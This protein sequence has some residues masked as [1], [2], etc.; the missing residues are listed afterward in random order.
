MSRMML[1]RPNHKR[2]V[3]CRQILPSKIICILWNVMIEFAADD[4]TKQLVDHKVLA[5]ERESM[6]R[7]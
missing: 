7:E 3:S 6:H 5:R 2:E 1:S 4:D